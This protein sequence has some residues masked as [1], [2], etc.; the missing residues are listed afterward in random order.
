MMW[1]VKGSLGSVSVEDTRST[2][3]SAVT[4]VPVC[5]CVCVWCVVCERERVCVRVCVRACVR[6]CVS[7]RVFACVGATV[8]QEV[9]KSFSNQKVV[10][11]ILCRGVLE[12]DTEPL[13]A[14]GVPSV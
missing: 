4:T 13:I 12:R 6:V 7:A 8:V 3:I 2:A 11:S 9:E 10:S 1:T 14:P 5:V